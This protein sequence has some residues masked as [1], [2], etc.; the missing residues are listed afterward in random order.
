MTG[1]AMIDAHAL[2]GLLTLDE[3]SPTPLYVQLRTRLRQAV[4]RGVLA[5]G[6][7]LPGE[8]ELARSAGISRVTVRRAINQ[9]VEDGLLVQR[10]GAGTF[11][12]PRIEQPLSV[13][14]A[15][16]EDMRV[17]GLAPGSVWLER[18]VDRPTPDEAMALDLSPGARV[19]RFARIRTADGVPMAVE[20]ASLPADLL[21][22]PEVVEGSLYEALARN[23]YRAT[24]ALQRLRAEL[25][26]EPDAGWL[27]VP[28]GSA[29]LSIER[30]AFL[31]D[32]RPIEFTRS[33]YRG[34]RYDFIAE[35]RTDPP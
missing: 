4:E 2:A 8:R 10:Q 29:V 13:L 11:I 19:L 26:A 33:R 9:L 22:G 15:F 18:G 16:S 1:M 20:R 31:A 14:S 6:E 25:V 34:D 35:L 5:A 23:G 27:G 12:A 30:R 17:R 32:G 21:P 24:R 7:A 28:A 3:N